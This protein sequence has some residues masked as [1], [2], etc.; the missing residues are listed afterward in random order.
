MNRRARNIKRHALATFA[1]AL[2]ALLG[3]E[4]IPAEA[5]QTAAGIEQ[6]GDLAANAQLAAGAVPAQIDGITILEGRWE[7]TPIAPGP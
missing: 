3:G 2:A 1:G 4:P 6:A 5:A 7:V